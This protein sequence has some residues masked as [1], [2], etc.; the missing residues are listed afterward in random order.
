MLNILFDITY[1]MYVTSIKQFGYIDKNAQFCASRTSVCV[2]IGK[3]C[4]ASENNHCN[5]G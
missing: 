1:K 5:A 3:P 2:S 4:H